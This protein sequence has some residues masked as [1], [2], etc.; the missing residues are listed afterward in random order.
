M[1]KITYKHWTKDKVLEVVGTMPP[2]L[3]NGSSDRLIVQKP[4]GDYE[5]V[6][7][8]TVIMIEEVDTD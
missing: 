2:E 7:K 6:I 4:Q 3:N 5:D 8:N 1:I